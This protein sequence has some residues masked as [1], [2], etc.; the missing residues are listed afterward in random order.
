MELVEPRPGSCVSTTEA[1]APD[2][3][4]LCE[5]IYLASEF[6]CSCSRLLFFKRIWE[7]EAYHPPKKDPDQILR[8]NGSSD[9]NSY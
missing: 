9:T 3:V 1:S 6:Q 2:R 4:T 5:L 7:I 8:A